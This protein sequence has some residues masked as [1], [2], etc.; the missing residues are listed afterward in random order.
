MSLFQRIDR[1]HLTFKGICML[2][3]LLN[4]SSAR[5]FQKIDARLE[6]PFARLWTARWTF[7]LVTTS[8]LALTPTRGNHWLPTLLS[9]PDQFSVLTNL[10]L[11]F[12]RLQSMGKAVHTNLPTVSDSSALFQESRASTLRL[13]RFYCPGVPVQEKISSLLPRVADCSMYCLLNS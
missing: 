13:R 12:H 11:L 9:I 4:H 5:L 7:R 1:A 6:G 2:L 8:G 3:N 10:Y